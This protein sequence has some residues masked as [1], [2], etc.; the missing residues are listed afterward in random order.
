MG[1]MG[2]HTVEQINSQTA[3]INVYN[4]RPSNTNYQPR[5][6]KK[7]K[8]SNLQR[9]TTNNKVTIDLTQDDSTYDDSV[10]AYTHPSRLGLV[11][12]TKRGQG[13]PSSTPQS[14]GQVRTEY[15]G[16]IMHTQTANAL[17]G[18]SNVLSVQLDQL[19]RA[20]ESLKCRWDQDRDLQVQT[21]T[22]DLAALNSCFGQM[23]EAGR[24][25]LDIVQGRLL[26]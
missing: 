22:D 24:D 14:A 1:F 16:R 26:K 13:P 17:N 15:R 10:G 6:A 18:I 25:A 11:P 9:T 7:V 8:S 2:S 4:K 3:S 19:A 21:V 23:E 12:G 20:R 5:P